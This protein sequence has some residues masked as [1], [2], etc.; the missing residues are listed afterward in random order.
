MLEWSDDGP[1]GPPGAGVLGELL[2]PLL[3]G[4]RVLV[5]GPHPAELLDAAA[6]GAGELSVLLRSH[7]DA[8]RLAEHHEA[9]VYCGSLEK[10]AFPEAFDVVIALDG[11]ERLT[12]SDHAAGSW[13]ESLGR[14]TAMLAPGG[15]LVLGVENPLGVHR[16]AG[17]P[18]EVHQR[19]D[20]DWAAVELDQSRPVNLERL[21][22]LLN[23]SGLT[24]GRSYAAYGHAAGPHLLLD[25][26]VLEAA[27]APTALA[28]AACVGVFGTPAAGYDA[29]HLGR[30]AI[31]GGLGARVAPRWVVMAHAAGGRP[32]TSPVALTADADAA[33]YWRL[34][35]ELAPA[36]RGGWT[37]RARGDRTL[38]VS[39]RVTRTPELLDGPVPEGRFLAEILMAACA[40]NDV[41]AI[42][43]L[44]GLFRRWVEGHGADGRVPASTAFAAADNVV[45][46]G[47]GFAMLDA[48]WQLPGELD[49]D[50]AL[51]RILR[52][53]AVRLLDS[54]Q[55]HPWSWQVGADRLTLTLLAMA[56]GTADR[57]TVRRGAELDAEIGADLD[58]VLEDGARD[59]V[60]GDGGPRGD[61]PE[62]DAPY[63]EAADRAEAI[64][65]GETHAGPAPYGET[66]AGNVPGGNAPYGDVRVWS[67][68]GEDGSAGNAW[69]EDG[70]RADAPGRPGPARHGS[71][72]GPGGWRESYRE[73]YAARGRL[74][75]RLE[76]A[77]QKITMLERDL[78]TSEAKLAKA[79]RAAKQ[80]QRRD[81][82]PRPPEGSRLGRMITAPASALR[83][84]RRMFGTGSDGNAT[85]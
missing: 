51:A 52:H 1:G 26:S 5:A 53:F 16:F 35:C 7:S 20:D 10:A 70:P 62:G 46:D 27:S 6:A 56:G 68:P 44:L 41:V 61:A 38:R 15:T 57:Q 50:V 30:M 76:E 71:A 80:A 8:C 72:G 49:L 42:R 64:P 77:Q 58:A 47:T 75:A 73:L 85:R 23:G 21:T 84:V 65:Y 81:E 31:A 59:G 19:P 36:A 54:G 13:A 34:S 11:V 78:E 79:V 9:T 12:S 63:G 18:S 2:R 32:V 67:A 48:S 43:E 22:D 82:R 37:R 24:V 83:P 40:R 55:W 39:G 29:R 3:T 28:V 4:G 14:L 25:V 74:R 17:D 33:P 60:P 45:F 69:D 66:Q